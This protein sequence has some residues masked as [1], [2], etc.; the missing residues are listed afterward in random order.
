G[1]NKTFFFWSGEEYRLGQNVIPT[2]ISVPTA[3]Y[4]QGNFGAAQTTALGSDTL[5]RPILNNTVYDP[6]TVRT[7]LGQSVTDPFPNNSVPVG[8]FDPVAVKVQSLIP[9]PTKPSLLAN[10]YQQQY[11]SERVTN[12]PSIKIDQLFGSKDKISFYWSMIH[13]FCWYCTGAD[14]FPLPISGTIGTDIRGNTTRLSYDRT[15]SPT[16]L[17]HLGAGFAQNNL[18]RPPLF[19]DYD[20]CGQLGLCGLAFA[21]PATFPVFQNLANG[22]GGLGAIGV[23]GGLGTALGPGSATD[24]IQFQPTAVANLTWVR[25]NHTYKFGG[26]MMTVG[27]LQYN[28]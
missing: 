9:Q 12:V 2:A 16:L 10:N 28:I 7:V 24:D 8:R 6:S 1:R 19:P 27:G 25:N 4:R 5:G 14:G 17:L 21:R 20:A 13:T 18:N 11:L 26:Q 23:N 22:Q 3:A 15:L